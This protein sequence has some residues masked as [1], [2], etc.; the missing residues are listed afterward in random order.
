MLPMLDAA[1]GGQVTPHRLW[2]LALSRGHFEDESSYATIQGV[3]YGPVK[4]CWGL[5]PDLF[6][7]VGVRALKVLEE[8]MPTPEEIAEHLREAGHWVWTRPDR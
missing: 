6:A 7:A 8:S 5:N 2:R 3:D 4:G 1:T